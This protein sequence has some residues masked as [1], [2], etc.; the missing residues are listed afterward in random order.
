MSFP[1]YGEYKD[2]G[3]PW[4]GEVPAHWNVLPVKYVANVVNGY[5]FDSALF[6]ASIGTPLVRI[7]DLNKTA[8][9]AFYRGE[10]VE[11][12]EITDADVLVGMDG[13]F[14]VGRWLGD[15]IALLNQRMCCVRGQS[16]EISRFLEYALSTP[17]RLIN[18]LTY[19][20]TVKHLA[21]SQIEKTRVAIS[22]DESELKS[23]LTFLDRETGK[24]DALIVEQEKLLTLLAEK[25]QAT[26]SHAVTRGL[27][28]NAPMK[29]S[30]VPWLGE[31][32]AHWE[33]RALKTI[34]STPITDG[35]HETPEFLDEG[36]PF[37]SAEAVGS[38]SINFE[39]IRGCIS[40]EDDAR[41]SQ[42]YKP[43]L[44]D[45]YMVKSGATTGVTAMVD[46]RTD[47]NIWS[48]L[49][50]IRCDRL[51]ADPFFV[52]HYLRSKNFQEAIALNWSFG[53][54]QNI[55][56]GVLGDLSVALP[57]LDEQHEIV[58]RLY[59]QLGHLP[60]LQES[61]ERAVD[62]LKERRSALIAA[63]VTGKIDVRGQSFTTE[64]P[65]CEMH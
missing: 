10:R 53:T 20:T 12:A 23:V 65:A 54:Q 11:V 3:V 57:P 36:V 64:A 13:D 16:E 31:V 27:N 6:D 24:I 59:A 9:E 38:G 39:K 44:R 63:A 29:D 15:G 5:P 1:R 58:Q 61:A 14:N 26:I 62:L 22:P 41:Y 25:R 4:L 30:G 56:M 7:R 47:F 50:A 51:K 32:P 60:S 34:V 48:P 18:D 55:G 45:I 19:A 46:E 8:T 42:K 43:Q 49:A 33:V 37:V 21:S 17:L 2:S 52:M 35:P 28:P 40:F